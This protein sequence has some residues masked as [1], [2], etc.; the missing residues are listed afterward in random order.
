MTRS[1]VLVIDVQNDVLA[2][3][4][5]VDGVVARIVSLVERAR[6]DGALVVWIQHT[7]EEM[8][9]GSEAWE[10]DARL[11]PLPGEPLLGKEFSDSFSNPELEPVLRDAGVDRVVLVGAQS[12]YCIRNTFH[13]AL[14]R[15]FDTV[16]VSDAHTTLDHE[17]GRRVVPA[18]E[19]V[20]FTNMYAADPGGWFGATGSTALAAEVALS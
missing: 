12:D 20:E 15:G 4:W 17:F 18:A 11:A 14:A 7:D 10:L 1:A 6:A 9:V 13:S 16:L 2:G 5:D 3:G 8:P 19:I